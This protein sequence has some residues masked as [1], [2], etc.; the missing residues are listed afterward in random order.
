MS[1][2]TDNHPTTLPPV[3]LLPEPL[4][5]GDDKLPADSALRGDGLCAENPKENGSLSKEKKYPKNKKTLPFDEVITY[6]AR[7]VYIDIESHQ[8]RCSCNHRPCG[9]WNAYNY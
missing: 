2:D 9:K 5:Q 3:P 6:F 1:T 4:R 8:L 7:G